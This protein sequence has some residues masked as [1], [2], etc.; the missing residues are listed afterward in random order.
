MP[1]PDNLPILQRRSVAY[2]LTK[3]WLRSLRATGT[4][5][6]GRLPVFVNFW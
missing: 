4:T 3:V 2:D 5:V 1:T 6:W